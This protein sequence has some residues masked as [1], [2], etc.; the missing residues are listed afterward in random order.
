MQLIKYP[1]KEQWVSLC[2]RPQIQPEALDQQVKSIM[3]AVKSEGDRAL[4]RFTK[5]YD[6][7]ELKSLKVTEAEFAAAENALTPSLQKALN[8]AYGNIERFHATQEQEPQVIET[9]PG[10]R[11]WRRQVGIEK[12]GLYIPGGTAPLFSSLLML[13]IPARLAACKSIQVCTPPAPDGSIH[14]AILYLAKKLK[15]TEVFKTGGAQA[16]AAFTY[17]TES[18]SAV[19]KIFGPGNQYVTKAK[20]LAQQQAVAIDMPAGPSEVLVIA[21][22]KA[23]ASFVAADLLSQAEHGPDS[24]VILLSNSM[25]MLEKSLAEVEQQLKKLPRQD[26]ARQALVNS[27][28][29]LLND[30]ETCLD[31]SNAYAP[32]HLIIA[33]ENAVELGDK[34]LNAGSV[35]LGAYSC[36]SAGDYAS[37]TNHTLPTNAY[38]RSYSG[39]SLDSFCRMITYQE[40]SPEGLQNIGPAIEELAEAEGLRAHKNAV[41]IRLKSITNV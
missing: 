28:A 26:V 19:D 17:G 29:I 14:P 27:K 7:A 8:L 3:E 35:F 38:A 9:Q 41:S 34:V 16:I 23:N 32:E 36:E 12:V 24:Q 20:E 6:Q 10:V 40:I 33:T 25:E 31:F 21:D 2:R 4:F 37:G 5:K 39:V 13:G 15:I 18:I 22:E 11:C 1:Q 30:L